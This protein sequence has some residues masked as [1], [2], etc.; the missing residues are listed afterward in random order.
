MLGSLY[1]VVNQGDYI[2]FRVNQN[3][4]NSFDGTTFAAYITYNDYTTYPQWNYTINNTKNVTL[5]SSRWV[6][7]KGS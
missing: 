6:A 7:H 4:S 5:T 1:V 2:R 3:V